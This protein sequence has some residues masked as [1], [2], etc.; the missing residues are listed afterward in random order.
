MAEQSIIAKFAEGIANKAGA[1]G[2]KHVSEA[3]RTIRQGGEALLVGGA[4]GAINGSV[5][6]DQKGVPLD[7]VAAVVGLGA[8]VAFPDHPN[9]DEARNAGAAALAIY[10]F[11][12]TE[13]LVG[14]KAASK[15]GID[16]H[17]SQVGADEDPVVAAARNL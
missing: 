12:M 7:G 9:V 10:G 2:M 13:K 4:L 6:L 8:A 1:K 14:K 5:G 11:R 3:G 16:L 17:P 15:V